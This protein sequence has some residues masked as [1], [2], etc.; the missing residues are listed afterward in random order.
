MAREYAVIPDGNWPIPPEAFTFEGFQ[1]W[2]E[3]DGFPETGRIDFLAGQVE[4][5]MSPEDLHT[6]SVVKSTIGSIL[7]G[8]IYETG[9]GDVYMDSTRLTSKPAGLSV[10]PDVF[11]I[12]RETL[13]AGRASFV[14]SSRG[15]SSR[16]EGSA[17]LVV[18]I[19]SDS[20]VKK[21]NQRLPQLYARAGV[22]ELWIVDCRWDSMR[23]EIRTLED[24][25]Y[26]LQPPESAESDDW[27]RSPL[28]NRS[29]RLIRW[30]SPPF[31]WRY[32][33]EHRA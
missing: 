6:H 14:P 31:P 24:G 28:L 32:R 9:F 30:P 19:V 1:R 2:I 17:D 23:F 4:V 33:L 25:R 3:S 21:D 26:V 8:L 10:E 22:P 27:V 16:V 29:V 12:L 7:Y 20:S 13:E 15:R 11:V 5:D 18:E